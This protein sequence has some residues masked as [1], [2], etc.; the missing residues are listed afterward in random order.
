MSSE[1]KDLLEAGLTQT[2]TTAVQNTVKDLESLVNKSKRSEAIPQATFVDQCP[3]HLQAC[4]VSKSRS[5]GLECPLPHLAGQDFMIMNMNG[6]VCSLPR[7]LDKQ[8]KYLP[9]NVGVDEAIE[10][11][12]RKLLQYDVNLLAKILTASNDATATD[13]EQIQFNGGD[14]A[15][16]NA[17]VYV[18]GDKHLLD[19]QA[20]LTGGYSST[21]S[22]T[23]SSS[24]ITK[25]NESLKKDIGEYEADKIA[26][27]ETAECPMDYGDKKWIKSRGSYAECERRLGFRWVTPT[28]HCYPEGLCAVSTDDLVTVKDKL[29]HKAL[30]LTTLT[31]AYNGLLVKSRDAELQK[32]KKQ[33]AKEKKLATDPKAAGEPT[34]DEIK[35]INDRDAEKYLSEHFK[36]LPTQTIIKVTDEAISQY[37]K[38][39]DNVPAR[40]CQDIDMVNMVQDALVREYSGFSG[41]SFTD[42][43]KDYS[44]KSVARA[45]IATSFVCAKA[46][47]G[48]PSVITPAIKNAA[49]DAQIGYDVSVDIPKFKF[50]IAKTTALKDVCEWVP[51][52]EGKGFFAPKWETTFT[53]TVNEAGPDGITAILIPKFDNGIIRGNL[54]AKTTEVKTKRMEY[55]HGKNPLKIVYKEVAERV[56]SNLHKSAQKL[57]K[58]Y[59]P[60]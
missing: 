56:M 43:L 16:S 9:A 15:I 55:N 10:L 59:K 22:V 5:I 3:S 14:S 46:T 23:S 19:T 1:S 35:A 17:G 26:I 42:I 52:D 28:G 40:M 54:N 32:I 38:K 12:S 8:E 4:D 11:V 57:S 30:L 31:K 27:F 24:L 36:Y 2:E 39:V 33:L 6:E 44:T 37:L 34:A 49:A 60:E 50:T 45:F 7:D 21:R 47:H 53:A 41:L 51:T 29:K 20:D 58:A 25:V 18:G 13:S 48:L